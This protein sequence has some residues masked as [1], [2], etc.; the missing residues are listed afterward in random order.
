MSRTHRHGTEKGWF[1]RDLGESATARRHPRHYRSGGQFRRWRV[2]LTRADN[3]LKQAWR[4]RARTC[5]AAARGWLR[6]RVPGLRRRVPELRRRVPGLRRRCWLVSIGFA[7]SRWSPPRAVMASPGGLGK[8][9]TATGAGPGEV[10][11]V[12]R[13]RWTRALWRRNRR[14]NCSRLARR[15][16]RPPTWEGSTGVSAAEAVAHSFWR[17]FGRLTAVE[18]RECGVTRRRQRRPA[19]DP[20]RLESWAI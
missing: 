13:S 20:P 6:R 2:R 14:A 4:A 1:R 3:M 16:V 10:V 9:P 11:C 5:S 15:E 7:G 12:S 19:S 17:R 18:M 8:T